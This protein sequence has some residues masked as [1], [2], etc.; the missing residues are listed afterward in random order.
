MRSR[1]FVVL[2]IYSTALAAAPAAHAGTYTPCSGHKAMSDVVITSDATCPSGVPGVIVGAGGIHVDLG[3]HTLTGSGSSLGVKDYGFDNVTIENGTIT[4]FKNGIQAW[5]GADN[6]RVIG[7]TASNNVHDVIHISGNSARV[8]ASHVTGGTDVGVFI[9]G[10]YARVR[11]TTATLSGIGM[12]IDGNWAYVAN[13][14]STY[15]NNDGV[16]LTGSHAIIQSVTS[17]NN[18]PGA[19]SGLSLQGNSN[20][21][22]SSTTDN[23]GGFGISSFGK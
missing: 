22:D 15:N 6:F 13:S 9:G 16:R 2:L 1:F 5:N 23:N 21:V 3:G 20:F 17:S 7:I 19:S 11:N 10:N 12:E 8:V 4:N 14:T 18:T